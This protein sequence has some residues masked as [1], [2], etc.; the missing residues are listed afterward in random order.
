[1]PGRRGGVVVAVAGV[2]ARQV[3]FAVDQV[4][5]RVFEGAGQQ[6]PFK[7]DGKKPRAG[8][9]GFVAGHGENPVCTSHWNRVMPSGSQHNAG[10]NSLFLQ[11]R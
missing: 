8:V 7:I 11:R 5:E 4:I 6:L 10:M 2:E 1:M 9:D 3:E